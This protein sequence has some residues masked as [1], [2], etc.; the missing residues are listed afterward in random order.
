MHETRSLDFL[1]LLC[2]LNCAAAHLAALLSSAAVVDDEV[3]DSD[4][5]VGYVPS[6]DETPSLLLL[7][8]NLSFTYSPSAVAVAA[9]VDGAC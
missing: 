3:D 4:V 9:L 8:F 1:V 7:L 5:A 2:M 6:A